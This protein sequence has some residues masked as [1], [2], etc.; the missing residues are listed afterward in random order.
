MTDLSPYFVD[1]LDPGYVSG[2]GSIDERK[3]SLAEIDNLWVCACRLALPIEL[4]V[5]VTNVPERGHQKVSEVQRG[6]FLITSA[7]LIIETLTAGRHSL[8]SNIFQQREA[9]KA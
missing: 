8:S 6:R 5:Q 4:Q 3:Y 7:F 9:C 1:V 2:L